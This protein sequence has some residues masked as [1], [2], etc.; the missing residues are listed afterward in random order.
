MVCPKCAYEFCWDC[1]DH[2]PAYQHDYGKNCPMRVVCLYGQL[3][4]LIILISSRQIISVLLF[5][6]Y[7]FTRIAF[8]T[9]LLK[10]QWTIEK[11][12]IPKSFKPLH[13]ALGLVAL[14]SLIGSTG[15][16][17]QFAYFTVMF[18]RAVLFVGTRLLLKLKMHWQPYRSH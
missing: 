8:I 11:K 17:A 10:V 6:Y 14:V 12:I 1:L 18:L 9:L 2:M 3:A 13:L 16:Y 15:E 5:F 4:L 7:E